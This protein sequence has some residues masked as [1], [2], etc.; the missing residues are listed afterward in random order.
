MMPLRI[1][2]SRVITAHILRGNGR[3]SRLARACAAAAAAAAATARAAAPFRLDFQPAGFSVEAGRPAGEHEV[4]FRREPDLSSRRDVVRGAA[5]TGEGRDAYL[6]YLADF[7]TGTIYLDLN[8]NLDLTDDP[9]GTFTTGDRGPWLDFQGIRITVDH[10]GVGV[11]Y[12]L[13]M[14]IYPGSVRAT[15]RSGW[16][17]TLRLDDREY[18]VEIADNLDG[19][20]DGNDMIAISPA[21]EGTPTPPVPFADSVDLGILPYAVSI[22]FDASGEDVGLTTLWEPGGGPRGTCA[23]Q[24]EHLAQVVLRGDH[25]AILDRPGSSVTLPTGDYRIE[26]ILV[27]AA[28]ADP[29]YQAS[30]DEKFVRVREGQTAVLEV[31]APL[32]NT[33]GVHRIG[34]AMSFDYRLLGREGAEYEPVE[35]GVDT[36]NPP[37]V[38]IFRGEG[39]LASGSFD[40]G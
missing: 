38:A 16:R 31:G 36:R 32:N 8:R 27:Q 30:P 25:L 2:G 3:W 34:P 11:P 39:K 1:R 19:V 26:R 33:A 9:D 13:T 15:V 37:Q 40:Y 14:L 24:G 29:L 18:R 6:G 35:G 10:G 21:G 4:E 7:E 20:F 5:R 22:E 28:A 12:V 17:G 23:I